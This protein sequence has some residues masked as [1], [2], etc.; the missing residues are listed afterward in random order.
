MYQVERVYDYHHDASTAKSAVLVDRLWPRG[1]SKARLAG[2]TWCKT[3]TPSTA[4]R[5]WFH[6]QPD[7][8]YQQFCQQ[9]HQELQQPEKQAALQELRQ[10][11]QEYGHLTLLTAVKNIDHSHIP[12]L[13]AVLKTEK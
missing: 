6:Q 8:R 12:V 5:Q 3:V 4:L 10:R 2:V 7:H 9:Y 11:A 13:L 1:I